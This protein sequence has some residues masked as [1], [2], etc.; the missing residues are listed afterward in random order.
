M[1]A[2]LGRSCASLAV[3]TAGRVQVGSASTSALARTV[4]LYGGRVVSREVAFT[5][6]RLVVHERRRAVEC[7]G[8]VLPLLLF[9]L[10]ATPF[11]LGDLTL[12]GQELHLAA[13]SSLL[14]RAM[15]SGV[16]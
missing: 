16:S 5:L 3:G 12:A 4:R 7:V 9:V 13:R 11:A 14:R 2:E 8:V 15:D 1:G 10:E 6:S